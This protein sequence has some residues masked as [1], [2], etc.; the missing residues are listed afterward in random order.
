[1]VWMRDFWDDHVAEILCRPAVR[2]G[3]WLAR[4]GFSRLDAMLL[5]VRV[6]ALQV[7]SSGWEN[8]PLLSGSHLGDWVSWI[9]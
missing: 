4:G 2:G 1:M 6:V 3:P 8:P 9:D 7:F 5:R